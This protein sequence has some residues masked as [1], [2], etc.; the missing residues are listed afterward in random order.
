MVAWY[1]VIIGFMGGGFFGI[2]IAA[3]CMAS[4]DAEKNQPKPK[5]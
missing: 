2:W 5:G 3:L 1:W 4:G